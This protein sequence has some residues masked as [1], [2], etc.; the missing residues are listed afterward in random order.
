MFFSNGSKK[1]R[2]IY[3]YIRGNKCG[4]INKDIWLYDYE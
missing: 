1:K 3:I 4:W 2:V